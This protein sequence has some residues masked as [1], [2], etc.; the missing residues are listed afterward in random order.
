MPKS[1]PGRHG[2][3]RTPRL[4]KRVLISGIG[5]SHLEHQDYMDDAV[6][7]RLTVCGCSWNQRLAWEAFQADTVPGRDGSDDA[8]SIAGDVGAMDSVTRQRFPQRILYYIG[9]RQSS[10]Y[11]KVY[12]AG[13]WNSL[14]TSQRF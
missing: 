7:T 13:L 4:A 8:Q 1:S 3:S 14:V 12:K 2:G 5:M 6:N 11:C 9:L 10:R